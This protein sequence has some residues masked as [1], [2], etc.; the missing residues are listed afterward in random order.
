M[1]LYEFGEPADID[2]T[3]LP[4]NNSHILITNYPGTE[5]TSAEAHTSVMTDLRTPKDK[6]GV[7]LFKPVWIYML[8]AK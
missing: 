2:K 8:T 5:A 7:P 4:Y 6:N 3:P 1:G